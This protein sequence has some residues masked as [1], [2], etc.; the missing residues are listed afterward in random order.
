MEWGSCRP[1]RQRPSSTAALPA[2]PPA[3]RTCA[4]SA[5]AQHGFE[6]LAPLIFSIN[7]GNAVFSPLRSPSQHFLRLAPRNRERGSRSAAGRGPGASARPHGARPCVRSALGQRQG[8][9]RHVCVGP[10]GVTSGGGRAEASRG[11]LT[12]RGSAAR[13]PR[14]FCFP[15]RTP[16]RGGR[17]SRAADDAGEGERR[18]SGCGLRACQIPGGIAGPGVGV[19][20][21][22]ACGPYDVGG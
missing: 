7:T 14:G 10:P 2:G 8:R 17:R 13:Q 9:G 6:R 20:R 4:R 11:P 16:S 18:A 5:R 3:A 12:A 1:P 15:R 19:L 21:G 22:S